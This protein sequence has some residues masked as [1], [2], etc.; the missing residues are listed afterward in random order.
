MF[1]SPLCKR[2]VLKYGEFVVS[3]A[4]GQQVFTAIKH[5]GPDISTAWPTVRIWTQQEGIVVCG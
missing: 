3:F 2:S 4:T 5:M 1:K